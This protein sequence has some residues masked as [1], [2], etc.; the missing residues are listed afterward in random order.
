M[1][2]I[3]DMVKKIYLPFVLVYYRLMLHGT[4]FFILFISGN[5]IGILF[6]KNGTG[7]CHNGCNFFMIRCNV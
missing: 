1:D 7:H 5:C 2:K 3:L 4:I 6:W